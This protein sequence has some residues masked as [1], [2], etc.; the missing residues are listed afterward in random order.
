MRGEYD[1][2]NAGRTPGRAEE[3]TIAD[4]EPQDVPM[5]KK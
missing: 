3:P 2:S 4:P 1:G 5:V